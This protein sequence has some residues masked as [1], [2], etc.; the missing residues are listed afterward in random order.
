MS[1]NKPN[2]QICIE[3]SPIASELI[4]STFRNSFI[5]AGTRRSRRPALICTLPQWEC[6]CSSRKCQFIFR[7]YF[8]ISFISSRFART[9]LTHRSPMQVRGHEIEMKTF[10]I[11]AV[12]VRMDAAPP[13]CFR[14]VW[15]SVTHEMMKSQLP[16]F[17]KTFIFISF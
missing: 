10:L 6:T 13:I 2:G 15:R 1:I 16:T 4:A 8:A 17:C 9:S 12:R 5:F 11:Y 3:P 7:H 14:F